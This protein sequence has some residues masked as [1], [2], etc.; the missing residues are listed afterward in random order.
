MP[1]QLDI[2]SILHSWWLSQSGRLGGRYSEAH[3]LQHFNGNMS[4]WLRLN[5]AVPGLACSPANAETSMLPVR[6]IACS[7]LCGLHLVAFLP[8]RSKALGHNRLLSASC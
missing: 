6:A 3:P 5:R 7:K 1:Q 8:P 4:T 2:F